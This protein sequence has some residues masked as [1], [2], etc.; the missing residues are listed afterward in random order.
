M[1]ELGKSDGY[2]V[3]VSQKWKWDEERL[4]NGYLE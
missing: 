1:V 2:K 4:S 3:P